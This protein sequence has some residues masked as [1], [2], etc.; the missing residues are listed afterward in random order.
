[1]TFVLQKER[2]EAERKE[3][4]AQGIADYQKILNTGLSD[5]LL[6]YEM[7]KSYCHITQFQ[8]YCDD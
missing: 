7:D 3:F 4:E 2:Q 5:K 6:Q 1:M 8:A